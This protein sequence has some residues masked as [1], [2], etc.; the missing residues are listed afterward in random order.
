MSFSLLSILLRKHKRRLRWRILRREFENE[1]FLRCF[2]R[3]G[4]RRVLVDRTSAW[5]RS[6]LFAWNNK[7]YKTNFRINKTTFESLVDHLK[8]VTRTRRVSELRK[9]LLVLLWR[10]GTGDSTRTI[11]HLFGIGRAS[12]CDATNEMCAAIISC[13]RLAIRFPEQEA[14]HHQ[15]E[16]GFASSSGIRGII[17]A[18]DGSHIH[19]RCPP[20]F[21]EDYYNRK[22][23]HSIQ[24]QGLVDNK[25]R[26]I[27]VR[28]P[29][30]YILYL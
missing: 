27:D 18:I 22:Q 15:I 8:P 2:A 26:F 9:K 30:H 7:E 21:Q 29:N 10:L 25:K 1:L 11:S 4:R 5:W 16:E 19:I 6:V 3:K 13:D 24:L 28:I 12:V 23:Y 14:K 20:A 17:G